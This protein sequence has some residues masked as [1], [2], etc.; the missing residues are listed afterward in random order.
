[1]T[2]K[3]CDLKL[4]FAGTPV[5]AATTLR[6]LVANGFDV[7]VVLTRPDAPIGRKQ[8]L[9][10]SAVAVEAARLGIPVIKSNKVDDAVIASIL[11]YQVEL[12]VVVAFGSLLDINALSAIKHGWVNVHYSLLPKYRGAAPVQAALLNQEKE[13]GV[14]V[15][16][17][18]EGMDT[19]DIWTQVPVAIEHNENAGQ[20]LQRLT[21]IGVSALAEVLP[22]I[23]A[24]LGNR[25]TQDNSIASIARKLTRADAR[26]DWQ[27]DA[28]A[29][30]SLV[31]AMNPEPMA[32]SEVAGESIRILSAHV[33]AGSHNLH[34]GL[35]L[36]E[37]G[38]VFVGCGNQTELQ[39]VE[40]QP[41]GKKEM[42]AAS[43]LNG[44]RNKETVKFD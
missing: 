35:I 37:A 29:I 12:G 22:Q 38:K 15:F 30:D 43:W 27:S 18:D 34:P 17:L 6:E 41:A 39:L 42:P 23:F 24:G 2:D 31:R 3:G 16:Q 11:S 36:L 32:W 33:S 4:V 25:T 20:L 9:T 10:E 40:V 14:T 1:M 13:T 26:V 7:A 8:I 19:G 28:A 21:L 44:L 5:N